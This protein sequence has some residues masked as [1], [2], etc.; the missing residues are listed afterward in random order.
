[1]GNRLSYIQKEPAMALK[2]TLIK[3]KSKEREDRKNL[4][5]DAAEHVFSTKPF[6]RVSMREIATEAGISPSS[7]YTYFPT[8]EALF[9]E[10]TV[11]DSC[12]LIDAVEEIIRDN[13][14]ESML[15]EKVIDAFIDYISTHDSYFRMM[16]VFMTVGSL[17]RD[18]MEK[19]NEVVR[20]GLEMFGNVFSRMGYKNDT[21][22]LSHYFFAMLNGILV[23]F[24]KLE[25]R[26]DE[27][28]IAHM[29]RVAKIFCGL[30]MKSI[31]Y[32]K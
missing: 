5:I 21:K 4:I 10:A 32:D 24:R 20:L 11:R 23:T 9:V 22:I 1:M 7:I 16:V 12:S 29:K 3:M 27:A 18:S 26:P 6:D 28:I 14:D 31:S 17:S 8:Q 30:L 19:L 25:G 15:L 13:A 2:N